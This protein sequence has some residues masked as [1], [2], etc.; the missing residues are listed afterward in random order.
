MRIAIVGAGAVGRSIAQNLLGQG[1]R[2]L[3]IESRKQHYQPDEVPEAS[4]MW[5]D[6]CELGTLQEAGIETCDVVIATAGDDRVNLVCALLSK[7]EFGVPRVIARVNDAANR[8][9]FNEGWGVDVAV[10][11]PTTTVAIVECVAIL[12]GLGAELKT[13]VASDPV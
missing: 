1:H 2:V 8:W 3:L 13:G 9:L 4:W 10:S 5:G 12:G 11:S 7:I 6:A